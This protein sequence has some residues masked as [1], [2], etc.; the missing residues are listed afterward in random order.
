[1]PPT[2]N[3]HV[4]PVPCPWCGYDVSRLPRDMV[5]PEC[6][7]RQSPA[8]FAFA[9]QSERESWRKSW[10]L[11][12][13]APGCGVWIGMVLE[14]CG[15]VVGGVHP[16]I[17]AAMPLVLWLVSVLAAVLEPWGRSRVVVLA[18]RRRQRWLFGLV[19]AGSLGIAAALVW[20]WLNLLLLG[21]LLNTIHI[22]ATRAMLT[23]LVS[24]FGMASGL[25]WAWPV[26][27]LR[28]G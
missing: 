1:M 24:V 17:V 2:S 13:L 23:L 25:M 10:I 19:A 9:A 5:C 4:E 26:M 18:V 14:Q 22:D 28:R 11:V 16:G 6:G 7:G 21:A 27:R 12:L 20:A 8:D 15:W 3:H